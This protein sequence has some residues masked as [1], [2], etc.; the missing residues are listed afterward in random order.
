MKILIRVLAI[1]VFLC[2]LAMPTHAGKVVIGGV[3]YIFMDI[4]DVEAAS[5]SVVSGDCVFHGIVVS[6][7]GSNDVT[8]DIYDNTVASG[9]R[10]IPNNTVITASQR[11]WSFSVDPPIWCRHGIYVNVSVAGGGTC[12]YIVY[13]D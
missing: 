4:S 11:A 3:T 5:A 2:I 7:D 8:L 13:Y 10:L 1:V 9:N 12:K 6:T